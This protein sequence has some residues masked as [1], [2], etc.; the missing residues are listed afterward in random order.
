MFLAG[1]AITFAVATATLWIGH[2]L[3]KIPMTLV[4]GVLAGVQT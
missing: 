3:L 1:A 2:R 4:L